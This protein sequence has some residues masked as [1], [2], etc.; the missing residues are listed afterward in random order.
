MLCAEHAGAAVV[1][2]VVTDAEH[3]LAAVA[4]PTGLRERPEDT[5]GAWAGDPRL[6]PLPL[7]QRPGWTEEPL[8]PRPRS[9]EAFGIAG[10]VGSLLGLPFSFCCGIGAVVAVPVA[11]ISGGL[12]F[13]ALVLARRS[14]NPQ[15]AYWLGGFGLGISLLILAVSLCLVVWT[16]RAAGTSLFSVMTP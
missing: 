2:P 1:G 4:P 9:G 3:A 16:W 5:A 15:T 6:E 7:A 8:V 10:L 14:R 11:L 13:T 12:G